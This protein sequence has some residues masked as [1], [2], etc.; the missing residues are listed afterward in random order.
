[1]IQQERFLNIMKYLQEN[2]TAALT[3]SAQLNGVS[4]DTARRDLMQLEVQGKLKRV[5]GGAVYQQ[6]DL[7][8][9]T[10]EVRQGKNQLAKRE[11]AAQLK[12]FVMEGQSIALND[13]TTGIEVAKFLVE[14][15][16]RLMILTNNIHI[17]DILAEARKFTTIIPGGIVDAV[18]G[19]LH[20]DQCERDILQ[21]NIDTAILSADAISPEKGITAFRPHLVPVMQAMMHAAQRRI[22]VA[23]H[24]KFNRTAYMNVCGVEEIDLVVSD[25]G[26][27]EELHEPFAAKDVTVVTPGRMSA[28]Q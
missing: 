20:G 19:A 21:Y 18:E 22:W 9:Q 24:S 27:P 5:R 14:N 12:S 17:L 1:M 3:E 25:S 26:F 23:D 11:A 4:M 8:T 15:Y 13:G 2:R 16:S 6:I 28:E 10:Y 7:G